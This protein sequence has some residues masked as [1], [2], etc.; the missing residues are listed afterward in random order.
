MHLPK[1]KIGDVCFRF[2]QLDSTMNFCA[3]LAELNYPEG[4]AVLA[5]EQ[6]AGRGTKGR[7]W[8]SA[9]GKGLYVS[10]LLRPEPAHLNHI[11]LLAGLASREA[12]KHLT[13]LE[14][15]LKWPNDLVFEGK[16]LGGILCEA[17]SAGEKAAVILGI[18]LNVNHAPEDFPE[19]IAGLATSLAIISG[20]TQDKEILFDFLGKSLQLWYNTLIEG[21]VTEIIKS[22]KEYL[23]FSLGQRLLVEA[24]A[25]K[26]IEGFFVDIDQKG[27]LILKV[28]Q[29]TRAFYSSE[30]IKIFS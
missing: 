6:T 2:D 11:P 13:D 1:M 24:T 20:R 12:I 3:R 15:R 17:S 23:S 9:R 26:R 8:H 29:E 5:E 14:I 25:G 27:G 22:Y 7:T 10:F 16:K 4:V 28:G 18:G 19:E 30:I 21:Q